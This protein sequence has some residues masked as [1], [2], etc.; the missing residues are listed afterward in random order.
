MN[1]ILK[2]TLLKSSI[3]LACLST[4]TSY[5]QEVEEIVVTAKGNQ[6]LDES[7]FTTH[8]FT[9]LD[10]EAA[11]IE[12]VPEL[13]DRVAG[14]SVTDSGGRGSST[15]VSVRGASTDQI[16]V[17]V[18]GIRV[19]SATTGGAALNSYPV[20]AIERI[21]VLKGPFSGIYG[22]DAAG[23][24]IQIFTKKGGDNSSSLSSSFGSNGLQ[25]YGGSLN[26]G[27]EKNSLHISLQHE[28]VSGFDRV[29]SD[30]SSPDRDGFRENVVNINGKTTLH[31][32]TTAS[33]SV[34]YTDAVVEFDDGVTEDKNLNLV[35]NLQS[36]LSDALVW[37]NIIGFNDNDAQ[38][39]ADA[40]ITQRETLNTELS[41]TFNSNSNITA[42]IDYYNEDIGDSTGVFVDTE[43]NNVGYYSQL[44]SDFNAFSLVASLRHDDNSDYGD[45]TNYNIALGYKLT[46]NLRFSVSN[47]TSFR[48]PSF[49][50]LFI[51]FAPFIGFTFQG[52]T[53]FA[54]NPDL[55][56]EESESYEFSF[57][58][59]FDFINWSLSL[60]QTDF[61]N[62][63]VNQ[64]NTL[65][66]TLTPSNVQSARIEGY[67]I[68]VN[69]NILKWD[70]GLNVDVLSSENLTTRERVAGLA[71][72]TLNLSVSR[73]FGSFDIAA[74]LKFEHDRFDSGTTDSRLASY[75]IYDVRAN[76]KVTDAL[77]ISAKVDNLF[78]KDYFNSTIFG[79][80]ANTGGRLAKVSLKYAF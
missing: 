10:I 35:L 39:G 63:I 13:L 50:D 1:H 29:T 27:D 26:L 9:E 53:G 57:N 70:I 48:A 44:V 37:N 42:G 67:E 5:A 49:N 60:Y 6:T 32:S 15:S 31:E 74:N 72:E 68:N 33:L 38:T 12:D 62:L 11:Q 16:I 40:F 54:G 69:T 24:V 4:A 34:L 79:D 7:L 71:E 8:V 36:Q 23:G 17:L 2:S 19:G 20:E 77:T 56:P 76:Y 59:D 64:T 58:G 46:E 78:D 3:A 80:P 21:E 45:D 51:P 75:A 61:D 14:I 52:A 41:Y 66:A 25:E 43:R 28:N 55:L 30:F 65:T 73:D 47:G 22:A 18:D